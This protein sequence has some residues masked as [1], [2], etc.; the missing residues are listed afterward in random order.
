[1]QREHVLA[2]IHS[3]ADAQTIGKPRGAIVWMATM[4]L[5]AT[6]NHTNADMSFKAEHT[7]LLRATGLAAMGQKPNQG[8]GTQGE[9]R[10]L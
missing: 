9:A 1:M 2:V 3:N 6:R 8:N 10:W 4:E 5:T 7:E